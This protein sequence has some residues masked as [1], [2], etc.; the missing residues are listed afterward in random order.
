MFEKLE[1]KIVCDRDEL[2]FALESLRFFIEED[3]DGF[4]HM[5]PQ[6]LAYSV[7]SRLEEIWEL[8]D[9]DQRKSTT[10]IFKKFIERVEKASG[11]EAD[12]DFF[13]VPSEEE[14]EE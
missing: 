10:E 12:I 6:F 4:T 1:S 5:T 9:W 8:L 11:Y 2:E 14:E 3:V 7:Q 13:E